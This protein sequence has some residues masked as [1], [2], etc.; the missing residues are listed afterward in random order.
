MK[1][2]IN[3]QDP[4]HWLFFYIVETNVADSNISVPDPG[5][6]RSR[7]RIKE[8]KY[9]YATHFYKAVGNMIRNVILAPDFFSTRI[10]GSKK[11][12]IPN[13]DPQDWLKQRIQTRQR[14]VELGMWEWQF[15]KTLLYCRVGRWAGKGNLSM[16]VGSNSKLLFY[17][18]RPSFEQFSAENAILPHGSDFIAVN[19][20]LAKGMFCFFVM[21]IWPRIWGSI[22]Q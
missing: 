11:H 2:E 17:G 14:E 12:Q 1:F 3:I 13:S 21:S 9:F 22:D 16:W 18:P 10:Q 6:K 5:S 15:I 7:I 19:V 8:F 20:R 4:Q